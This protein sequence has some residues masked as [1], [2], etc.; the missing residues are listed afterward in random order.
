[1]QQV[2]IVRRPSKNYK[3]RASR[4]PKIDFLWDRDK[5]PT[6]CQTLVS[7]VL[8]DSAN[9]TGSFRIVYYDDNHPERR[10]S[11]YM[12]F[13]ATSET[14]VA[15]MVATIIADP[16]IDVVYF[17]AC[18]QYPYDLSFSARRSGGWIMTDK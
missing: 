12:E 10:K 14:D 6:L 8:K 5:V 3:R 15:G 1:M 17:S 11:D 9:G 7:R 13:K 2:K 4:R 18:S 16:K